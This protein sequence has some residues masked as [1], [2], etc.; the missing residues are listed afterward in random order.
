MRARK[1]L[2][3]NSDTDN[4]SHDRLTVEKTVTPILAVEVTKAVTPTVTVIV[5]K[6]VTLTVTM[7]VT[8]TVTQALR[9]KNTVT[10]RVIETL[11]HTSNDSD[12][13][14][15][16]HTI[17]NSSSNGFGD[18]DSDCNKK[19]ADSSTS[20][21]SIYIISDYCSKELS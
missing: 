21:T 12:S 10:M 16:S 4:N 1:N 11:I 6:T 14:K 15:N 19:K 2:H 7:T 20:S 9:E 5:T 17:I 13:A 8:T 18:N 3:A